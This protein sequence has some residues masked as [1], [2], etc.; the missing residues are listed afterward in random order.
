MRLWFATGMQKATLD[1]ISLFP[2]VR[3]FGR[4][5]LRLPSEGSN[6]GIRPYRK[7][8]IRDI[9]VRAWDM[10]PDALTL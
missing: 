2:D 9:A 5:E 3:A 4:Y 8:R 7:D 1:P 6:L 10:N